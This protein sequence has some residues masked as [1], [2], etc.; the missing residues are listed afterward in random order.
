MNPVRLG[1]DAI[2]EDDVRSAALLLDLLAQL[3][4]L[5][6]ARV[7]VRQVVEGPVVKT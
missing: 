7:V 5:H 6:P 1:R 3:R 4:G 2:A